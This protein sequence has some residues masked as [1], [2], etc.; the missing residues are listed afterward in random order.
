M[1]ADWHAWI[2]Q[3]PPGDFWL[4]TG[5]F[6]IG[7]VAGGIGGLRALRRARVIEDTPTSR[8]RSAA[9][10]YVELTGIGHPG[11][12]P[13]LTP[14]TGTPCCW[15][16]CR[17]ERYVRSGKHSHWKTVRDVTSESPLILRDGTGECL[18]DPRGAEVHPRHRRIWYGNSVMPARG[19]GGGSGLRRVFGGGRYRYTEERLDAGDPLYAI[20]EFVTLGGARE[21]LHAAVGRILRAWKQD[22]QTLLHR[23]DT[24]GDGRIDAD[25]WEQA[26]AAARQV[27]LQARLEAADRPPVH[28][29]G[30]PRDGRPFILA[31]D[32]QR[33]LTRRYRWQAAAW[34][35]VFVLAAP[36][37]VWMLL[38]RLGGGS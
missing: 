30:R 24:D 19:P 34:T 11:G 26:R 32:S 23:F 7:A 5:L 28:T 22:P 37:A 38:V 21:D 25:E 9:Q 31:T 12:E 33:D 3:A 36:S 15:Y 2:L 10:G 14:L 13:L 4:V 6:A 27:A 35:A 29:L 20:G 16:H 1:L 18:I 17:V 8:I